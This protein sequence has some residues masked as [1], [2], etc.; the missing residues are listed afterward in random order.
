VKSGDKVKVKVLGI[1][2][3]GK[4]RLSM[5]DVDQVSGD[6]LSKGTEER[7]PGRRAG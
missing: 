6:D 5:K 1:D 4:V 2:D 7:R 3:R